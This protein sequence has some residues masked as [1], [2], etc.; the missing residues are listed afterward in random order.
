MPSQ[1][2]SSSTSLANRVAEAAALTPDATALSSFGRRW[3]YA[4]LAERTRRMTGTLARL[5][6]GPDKR[7]GLLLPPVPT[8][9]MAALA[10]LR[11]GA[12]VVPCDP[13]LRDDDLAK[14]LARIGSGV[15]LSLD[16]TRLQERWLAASGALELDAVL[17]DKMAE[18]LPFPRNLLAPLMRGGE[19]APTPR[20]PGISA[21][22]KQLS[23]EAAR[24]NTLDLSSD[25]VLLDANAEPIGEP[26]LTQA[27]DRLLQIAGG[28]GRWL[29]A[30]Q[31]DSPWAITSLLTPLSAGREA[32]LLPRLDARTV[33]TAIQQERPSIAL[34]S[35]GA[36]HSMVQ[37][38]PEAATLNR[39][40]VPP[41]SDK[42]TRQEL[43]QATGAEVF[44][45]PRPQDTH[46]VRVRR[47]LSSQRPPD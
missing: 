41:D 17:I 8:A 18:L 12:E 1:I 46:G 19:I 3:S 45:W 40:V 15:L 44:A 23:A 43:A 24:A 6:V 42:A 37:S 9:A 22:P 7:L 32:L 30:H 36:A 5:D 27:A 34:L 16:L 39:L 14:S 13:Q 33:A 2:Y 25:G 11:L 31:I 47:A 10:G 26:Q 29:L 4:E 35:A 28:A 38:P 21:L 20:H